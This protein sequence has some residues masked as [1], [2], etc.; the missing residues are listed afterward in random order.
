MN[1]LLPVD[2]S[3]ASEKAVMFVSRLLG[4]TPP[5]DLQIT[6]YHVAESLPDFI[7]TRRKGNAPE[8]IFRSVAD[9]WET[10][11]R[12]D[13]EQLLAGYKQLLTTSG[14]S[15]ASVHEKLRI[16]EGLPEAKKVIAAMDIIHEMQRGTYDVIVMGRR[17][18]SAANLP[19]LGSVSEKV[20]REAQGRTIWI[21]D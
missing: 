3:D 19:F 11:I 12:V 8:N 15:S 2:A 5:K 14:I 6:L 10:N 7:A 17:A 21:V 13:G 18:S 1:I 16:E 4:K 20:V 9:E